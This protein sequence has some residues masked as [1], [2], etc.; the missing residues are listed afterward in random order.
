V[1][2]LDGI[3][4]DDVVALLDRRLAEVL[5]RPA[6]WGGIDALEP[7]VLTLLMLRTQVVN[8]VADERA[9]VRTYRRFLA[10]EFGAGAADLR[11]RL[12]ADASL[13]R[14]V[15]VLRRFVAQATGRPL[16]ASEVPVTASFDV[17][18]AARTR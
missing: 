14:V 1:S 6:G 16:E 17:L 5:D 3:R 15:D 9:V 10:V 13:A 18:P 2:E 8:P 4:R 7:L 12:G 11:T